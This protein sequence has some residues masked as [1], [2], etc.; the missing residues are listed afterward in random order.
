MNL[1]LSE[2]KNDTYEYQPTSA[3]SWTPKTY[4][5]TPRLQ[6]NGTYLCDSDTYTLISYLVRVDEEGLACTCPS[7][8]YRAA[9]KHVDAVAQMR[10]DE[11]PRITLESLYEW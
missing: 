5:G 1:R 6:P 2:S 8:G 4:T 9:C 3:P 11:K 10:A 7:F